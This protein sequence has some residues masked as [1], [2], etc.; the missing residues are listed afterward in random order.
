MGIEG[1][2]LR[3]Y[4]NSFL[5]SLVHIPLFYRRD[6]MCQSINEKEDIGR[7]QLTYLTMGNISKET[8]LKLRSAFSRENLDLA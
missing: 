6:W 5:K 4:S 3:S 1:M 2:I 7:R 8:R